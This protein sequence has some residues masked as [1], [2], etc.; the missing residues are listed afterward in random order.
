MFI[1]LEGI[2]GAGK[3]SVQKELASRLGNLNREVV[4]T[5]E[6]G[7]TA[8]GAK[9]RSIL[10]DPQNTQIV[11][12]A[13]LLLFAADRAQHV[14]EVIK[15]AL[16]RKAIVICD[17]FI[18]STLVYQGYGRSM[19]INLLNTLNS[20]ATNGLKPDLVLLLDLDPEMG[21]RRAKS[22]QAME[23]QSNAQSSSWSRFEE[24][25]LPFHLRLRHGFLELAK[26]QNNNFA[27]IDA[28]RPLVEVIEQAY[29]KISE[30][31]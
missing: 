22:R 10:L 7:A 5:R 15:P 24:E 17:R 19:N 18:H 25:K 16:E 27:I 1:T 29:G 2:E 20:L 28:S 9:I 30:N 14:A 23:K 8:I 21:L 13:E 4:V 12:L 26:D 11:P 3:S 31:L 6:P